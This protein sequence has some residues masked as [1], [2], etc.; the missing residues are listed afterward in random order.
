MESLKTRG[1]KLLFT[2]YTPVLRLF[3]DTDSACLCSWLWELLETVESYAAFVPNCQM[4]EMGADE[5]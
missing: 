2:C 1:R 3:E 4:I 5:Q